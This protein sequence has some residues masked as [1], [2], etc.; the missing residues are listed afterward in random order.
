MAPSGGKS[1]KQ[2]AGLRRRAA[3][4][5]GRQGNID[6]LNLAL[7]ASRPTIAA[8][9][10]VNEHY[11][12]KV[13]HI[14]AVGDVV[15]FPRWPRRLHGAGP[16]CRRLGLRRPRRHLQ[17]QLLSLRHLP[18]I[19]E[20]SF[21]GQDRRAVDRRGCALRGGDGLLPGDRRGQIRGDTT[22]RLKLIS[23]ATPR[24]ILGVHIIGEGASELVHIGQAVMTLGGTVEYF[25]DTVFNYPTLASATRWRP[26]TASAASTA[27]RRN[28]RT[29]RIRPGPVSCPS[30]PHAQC[31][32]ILSS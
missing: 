13:E 19:P 14:F 4:A 26:S 21:I 9:I 29:G 18:P 8:R 5:V 32:V 17:P 22:G 12:T 15:G 11:Q 25:I 10:P 1:R 30:T 20:I 16:H 3:Y 27:I 23:I 28:R 31:A 6:D 24:K 7:P 2:E